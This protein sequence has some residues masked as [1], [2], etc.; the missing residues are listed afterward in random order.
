MANII[1]RPA[2]LSELP[3]INA[4]RI[5]G[6][7][8]NGS[9]ETFF[10]DEAERKAHW[11]AWR[12]MAV[13][14]GFADP[15]RRYIVAIERRDDGTEEI[16]GS[17]EWIAPGGPDP[18]TPEEEKKAKAERRREKWP[19]SLNTEPLADF[20]KTVGE[21]LKVSL[22]KIGMPGDADQDMWGMAGL[23][24]I[25]DG[26]GANL[27]RLRVVCLDLKSIAVDAN[28]QRKGIGQMLV[29][30]GVN[31]AAEESKDVLIIANPTG[32][33][34]YRKMGFEEIG[35]TDVYLGMPCQTHLRIFIMR[36]K[37]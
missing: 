31:R 4:V 32:A 18:N 3:A 1:I 2:A 37:A 20:D 5:N 9:A 13:T 36:H 33:V 6:F 19:K 25:L 26:L 24:I 23:V 34:L 29:Q 35:G 21:A 30:W 11:P 10:P 16:A 28:H 22:H 8:G 14:D 12:L 7:A 27:S 17:A 15:G